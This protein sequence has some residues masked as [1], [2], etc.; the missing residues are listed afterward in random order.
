MRKQTDFKD[1]HSLIEIVVKMNKRIDEH[2]EHPSN[3][4]RINLRNSQN[5]LKTWLRKCYDDPGI[6]K[7]I[8][9][10]IFSMENEYIFKN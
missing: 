3:L 1:F 10:D 6:N 7:R 8:E 9:R 2:I 4:T 5:N